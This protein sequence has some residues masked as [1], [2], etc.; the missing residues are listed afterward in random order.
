MLDYPI[1]R[2]FKVDPLIGVLDLFDRF[3][4]VGFIKIPLVV[5]DPVI[6]GGEAFFLV[7]IFGKITV[8][9]P[10]LSLQLAYAVLILNISADRVDIACLYGT[11]LA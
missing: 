9:I 3:F 5:N 11:E 7:F 1:L 2:R 10:F 6:G 4:P 8:L